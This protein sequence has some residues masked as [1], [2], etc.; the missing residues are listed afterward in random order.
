MS[1]TTPLP[2]ADAGVAAAVTSLGHLAITTSDLD[3]FTSFYEGLLGLPRVITL[4]MHQPPRLRYSVFAVGPDALRRTYTTALLVFEVPGYD[5]AVDGLGVDIGRRGRIDH[6]A[7]RVDDPGAFSDVRSQLV[8]AGASNGA[9]STL[10]PF[11][12]LEFRDPDGLE[13]KIVCP[14]PAFD[15]SEVEDELIACSNPPWNVRPPTP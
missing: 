10:G 3:R 15:P 9:V 14:N 5:P 1:S 8:A 6:F 7:L 13:G 2:Y 11:L 12:S 4:R